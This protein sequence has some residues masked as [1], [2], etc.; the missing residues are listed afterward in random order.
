MPNKI[1]L[2]LL[3]IYIRLNHSFNNIKPNDKD[4]AFLLELASQTLKH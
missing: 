2:Y 1:I 4:T 3:E